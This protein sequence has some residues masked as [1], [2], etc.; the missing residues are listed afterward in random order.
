M[1]SESLVFSLLKYAFLLLFL[2]NARS[3]PLIWH[4]KAFKPIL[5]LRLRWY[6]LQLC[7]LFKPKHVKWSARTRWLVEHCP[8]GLDPLSYVHTWRSWASPDDCDFNL[9]LSNSCYAKNLDC[10]R[11]DAALTC[12]PTLFRT[13]GWLA[14]GATHYSFLREIPMFSPYEVR[15]QIAAWDSKWIFIVARYVTHPRKAS[16][17]NRG[18]KALSA[19][20][21]AMEKKK[22]SANADADG[23]AHMGGAPFPVLHTPSV[24]LDSEGNSGVST[25]IPTSVTDSA[26]HKAQAVAKA[27]L[28]K[29]QVHA[30]P[31]G[32][33]LNCIA[34]T[35]GCFKIGRI[36]V[37]PALVLAVEGFTAP[38]AGTDPYSMKN[39]PPFWKEAQ[40]LVG[41]DPTDLRK[42]KALY[43]GEW[44]EVPEG[45]RWWEQAL[46][47]LEERRR[48]GID[49][50]GAL[51]EGMEGLRSL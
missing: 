18:P 40:K 5:L 21:N 41:Q 20:S 29:T 14:L 49:V 32:A 3:W 9:H 30:E 11:V 22:A 46:A 34:V 48:A 4:M 25:P 8:V 13:G 23:N 1:V 45:K 47:G 15:M 7:L 43:A 50:V 17:K 39:P 37:P 2:V 31:D 6:W 24:L 51:R 26:D 27:L 35:V 16:M 19:S 42:L 10:V 44:R 33:T 12:F 38:N 28:Q 36:T